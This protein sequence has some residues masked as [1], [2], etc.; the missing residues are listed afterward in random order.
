M[1]NDSYTNMAY[2]FNYSRCKLQ[3]INDHKY[4]RVKFL[5]NIAFYLNDADILIVHDIQKS[6]ILFLF[7]YMNCYYYFL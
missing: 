1:F 3:L 7:C 5:I 2:L 4:S 6:K